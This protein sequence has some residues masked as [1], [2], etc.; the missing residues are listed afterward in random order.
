MK[1]QE[2]SGFEEGLRLEGAIRNVHTHS[3]DALS[4]SFH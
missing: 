4:D 1:Y 3:C 2:R